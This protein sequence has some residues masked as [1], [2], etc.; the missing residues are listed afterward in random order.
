MSGNKK[1]VRACLIVNAR[2]ADRTFDLEEAL[3]VLLAQGWE[4][5]VR[6]KTHKGDATKLA[7]A[8]AKAGYDPIVNCGG[9][10]TLNEIVDALTGMDV[11]VGVIPGGTENVWSKQVG[12]SQRSRVAAT[13]LVSGR[14]VRVDVGCVE[15]DGKHRHHF[16][17]MA[18]IGTD[19]AVMQRVSRSVKNRIGPLAVGIAAVEALPSMGTTHVM[20]EMDGVHWNGEISEMIVGNIRDYGGFTR[21]TSEAFVDDGL[22]DICL[23]TTDGLLPAARQMAS[24]LIRQQP[25][26]ASSEMYRAAAATVRATSP[27]AL[28]V[29]GSSVKQDLKVGMVEYGF[30]VIPRGLTVLVPRTYDGEIFEYGMEHHGEIEKQSGKKKKGKKA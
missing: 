22:L 19:G 26:Q 5:D 12:I 30:A 14:R 21:I 1:Q 15:I 23:F 16:L 24:L 2:S 13:Q 8:A 29:D 27:L 18:G 4:I 10:G 28:Q 6:E 17:M 25:S 3:P 9:D 20:V 11:G 7:K